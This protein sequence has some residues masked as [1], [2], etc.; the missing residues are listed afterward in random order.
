[1]GTRSAGK[2][3]GT[4]MRKAI[5]TMAVLLPVLAAACTSTEAPQ[6]QAMGSS[7]PMETREVAGR[8]A[9]VW[10]ASNVDPKRYTRFIIDP[11]EVYRGPDAEFGGTGETELRQLAEFTRREFTRALGDVY[12]ATAPGP[13]T[14]RVKLTIAGLENNVPGAATVTR[15]LPVGLAMNIANSALGQPGSFTGSVTIAGEFVDA[16]S[17]AP[18]MS[19]VQKRYPDA[20]DIGAT[21]TTRDAQEAAITQAADAFRKRLDEIHR[22]G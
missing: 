8:T 1:M 5:R 7:A 6:L 13:D 9:L 4:A 14:A 19:F 11:V 10:R 15:A 12:L 2:P 22:R 3:E 17:N 16:S 20:L 18:L 21:L